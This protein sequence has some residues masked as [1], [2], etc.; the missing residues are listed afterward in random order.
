MTATPVVAP[1]I[2]AHDV[3]CLYPT[4]RGYVAALRGLSLEV[5]AGERVVVHGPNG[6]GKTTLMRVLSGELS[7]SAGIV[8][9]AGIDLVGAED[10][11]R[12]Q[13]R[14]RQ[15]GLVDQYHAGTLRPELDVRSNVALQLRVAGLG[16]GAARTRALES[17]AALGLEHLADR[18]PST[19]SGGEAQR[20]A[21]CAALAHGPSLVLADEPTG[22]LDR[23]AADAVYDL[24]ATAT[25][26]VGASLLLVSHDA[27]AARIA[28]RVIR[29]RDGRLSEEWAPERLGVD[30]TGSVPVETLVVDDRGWLRLPEGLR[31]QSG[32]TSG[33][34]AQVD[35]ARIV[36][37]GQDRHGAPSPA[38]SPADHARIAPA[39]RPA[40]HARIAPAPPPIELFEVSVARGGRDLLT[41]FSLVVP[42]G[43]LTVVQGPSGSGKTTLLR[44][45]T[46]LERPDRGLV[47][48]AGTDLDGL[49]RTALARLRRSHLSVAGQ[50]GSLLETLDV[51]E[52]LELVRDARSL[53]PAPALVDSW[54]EALGLTPLRH[55]PVR[56]L[57]GGE[58]QRVAV[59]RALAVDPELTVMDE[60]T[61]QLDEV[62]A[63]RLV[64]VL[65]EAARR[66]LAVVVA[67]HDPVLVAVAD[68]VVIMGG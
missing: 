58:R 19:L 55:R 20:V 51:G 27:R 68:D 41:C 13:L 54:I 11:A 31:R 50:S 64:G 9:V 35:G 32:V 65:V 6:S 8:R 57:S 17:L 49:D 15:L 5:A 37:T 45:M 1:G 21:V 24:L 12:A 40:D 33:V 59:A 47:R 60:P 61:S 53:A 30:P 44:L 18:R 25:A 38:V 52:N 4:P 7:P 62:N 43:R 63:E 14:S 46:G 67:T 42:P 28:D 29:I 39:A 3:F 34:R 16:A 66:G 22:E 2:L 48:L 10:V 56:L 26:A 36:L 23:T